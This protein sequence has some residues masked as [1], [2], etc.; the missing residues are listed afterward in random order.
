MPLEEQHWTD[1]KGY[2]AKARTHARTR[3]H[4]QADPTRTC[5][6]EGSSSSSVSDARVFRGS[7]SKL[8]EPARRGTHAMQVVPKR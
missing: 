6:D 2:G 1:A 8:G 4:C 7:I 3:K 5:G